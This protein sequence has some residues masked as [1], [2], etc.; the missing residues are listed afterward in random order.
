[1]PQDDPG[2]GDLGEEHPEVPHGCSRHPLLQV[3]YAGVMDPVTAAP[4]EKIHN[5]ALVLL[6]ARA[7]VSESPTISSPE[8]GLT[9]ALKRAEARRNGGA[10]FEENHCSENQVS[11]VHP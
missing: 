1:M 11:G 3:L 2:R 9:L 5:D 10:R 4:L 7:G 8:D 6:T